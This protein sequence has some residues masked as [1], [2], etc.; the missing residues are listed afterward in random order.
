MPDLERELR[1]LD[2]AVEFPATPDLAAAVRARIEAPPPRPAFAWRRPLALVLAVLVAGL[3][4][5][6]AVPSARTAILEWLGLRGV[7]IERV[8]EQPSPRLGGELL[9]GERSTLAEARSDAEFRV[10]VPTAP[11]YEDPDAVYVSRDSVSGGYVSFVYGSGDRVDVLVSQ[12]RARI[13]EDFIHKLVGPGTGVERVSVSGAPGF[14]IEGPHEILYVDRNGG[15][16][17]ERNRLAGNT[18]LW[19]VGAVT[20]RLEGELTKD[21]ALRIAGSMR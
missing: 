19:Q 13:H 18:L 2:A 3:A 8:P 21:E 7:S 17:P 20:Y 9:L 6:M 4:A 12:F 14:W 5:A 11:G 15:E 16:I 1:A 10:R